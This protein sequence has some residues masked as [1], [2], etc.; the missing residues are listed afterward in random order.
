MID[1]GIPLTALSPGQYGIV[2]ELLGDGGMRRRLL[3][4]GLIVGT[5]IQCLGNSPLG[6]PSAYE[7][8][9]TVIALRAIDAARVRVH[10][11]RKEHKGWD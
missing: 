1:S 9:D 2:V 8:R 7:F 10:P 5:E 11:R 4:L 6:D 3:D